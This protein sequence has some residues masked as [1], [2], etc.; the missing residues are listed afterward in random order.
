MTGR[1]KD[2]GIGLVTA[3]I[4]SGPTLWLV[5]C[6]E[7]VIGWSRI[8]TAGKPHKE[9]STIWGNYNGADRRPKVAAYAAG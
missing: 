1:Q 9:T 8:L 4:F 2:K 7:F 3:T 6:G 5:W